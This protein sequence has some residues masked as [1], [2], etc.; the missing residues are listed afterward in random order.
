M[1]KGI[2][3]WLSLL[4]KPGIDISYSRIN[5]YQSC[6]Y[7][8]KIIYVDGRKVQP[9]QFISLGISIHRTLE[10]FHARK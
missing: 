2:F 1:L 3:N 5:A 9:N 4:F 8:F 10:K 7:K 6:P